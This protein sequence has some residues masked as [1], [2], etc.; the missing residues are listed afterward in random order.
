MARQKKIYDKE[1][2]AAPAVKPGE[3][4]AAEKEELTAVK[5]EK[6]KF[7][8]KTELG[9]QVARGDITGLKDI[10]EKGLKIKEAVIVDAL[11]PELFSDFVLIGQARGKFGGGK[12]RLIKQTQKKT[13]EGNKPNFSA[14]AIVGNQNGYAGVGRGKAKESMPAREKALRNAKLNLLEMV[15]GCGSWKCGCGEPHSLPYE[16]GGK[17]GSVSVKLMPAPKGT[18]LVCEN[19]IKKL[20]NAAGYKDIWAKTSGQTRH[21]V[22]FVYATISALTKAAETKTQKYKV[23]RG[24]V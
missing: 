13:A 23:Y 14:L 2:E 6:S 21:K 16:V 15:R 1:K 19:E 7:T 8:F 4:V 20:M 17:S 22:N 9:R 11:V 10:F 3:I 12:R 24:A 5:E 18:G